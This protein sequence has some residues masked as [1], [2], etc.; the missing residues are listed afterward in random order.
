M[1]RTSPNLDV[2][3]TLPARDQ[4]RVRRAF[5]ADPDLRH[6]AEGFLAAL[7]PHQLD[8]VFARSFAAEL[9]QTPERGGPSAAW[10]ALCS[11]LLEARSRREIHALGCI[12]REMAA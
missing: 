2:W 6:E 1:D 9:A 4:A 12:A 3:S 10:A 8:G 7:A 11:A 5:A